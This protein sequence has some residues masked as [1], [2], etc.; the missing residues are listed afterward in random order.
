MD[1]CIIRKTNTMNKDNSILE[2]L[3]FSHP[4][5]DQKNV[6]NGLQS[7]I[8]S[9]QDFFILRGAAGTGKTSI[10][11]AVVGFLNFNSKQLT[12]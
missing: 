7:F 1:I 9:D 4:T 12:T 10:I 5:N 8:K 2:F 11:S 6:L 3:H